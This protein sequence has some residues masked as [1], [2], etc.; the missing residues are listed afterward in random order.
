MLTTNKPC[1]PVS[2][3][4]LRYWFSGQRTKL[5]LFSSLIAFMFLF[6]AAPVCTLGQVSGSAT[7]RGI[8]KDPKGAVVAGATVTLTNVNRGDQRQVTTSDEG[9]Y[10][11][12]AVDPGSYTLKVEA[13]GFKTIEQTD[14]TLSPSETRSRDFSLEIG[15]RTET[16]T[17]TQEPPLI[18]TE[19]GER[20]DTITA[21]QID[22]LSIIGRSSLE[23]LRILP[24]VV[25][26]DPGEGNLDFNTFGGGANANQNY[27]V[28]GIRGVNNT[29]NI[30]GSRVMDI[31]SN[32]G[33]II[34]ANIDMVQEVTVKSSNYAPEYGSSGVHISVTTKGGGKDFHGEVYDYLR[35]RTLQASDRSNTIA[36]APRPRTNFQY[37]G[38]QI[39]GPI[40]LPFT[41]FN[42]NRDKLFFF[43]AFEWQRQTRDPGTK[44]G[45]VPTQAERNGDFSRSVSGRGGNLFCPPD[46]YQ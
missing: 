37:P 10:V 46:T 36:G 9:A 27:Y 43:F 3:S 12:T 32:N 42:R 11:F 5:F 34:T 38:G 33:T 6:V 35:P 18:K 17:V 40:L 19:T 13:T 30:D 39:G 22:N 4:F 31:G 1:Q 20:S 15:A 45:T 21:K 8:V 14:L 24:G 16:V 7:L 44:F 2:H 29:V 26:P 28:N 23:L 25:A 41:D